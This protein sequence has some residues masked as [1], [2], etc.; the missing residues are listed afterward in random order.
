MKTYS[1]PDLLDMHFEALL[2]QGD[3]N[4]A[5]F[6]KAKLIE[7]TPGLPAEIVALFH[8]I[9]DL[10]AFFRPVQPTPVFRA[11]LN[12]RLVA[13]AKRQQAQRTLG[14]AHPHPPLRPVWVAPV[15]VLGTA[16]LV[17]VGAYAYWR[18]TR[19]IEP[20]ERPLAA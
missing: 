9:R 1:Y 20:A 17:G 18:R 16:S 10:W 11:D 4:L 6:A 5:G 12:A 8:L 3:A 15:A 19:Q 2:Q 13:E 7:T 14:I